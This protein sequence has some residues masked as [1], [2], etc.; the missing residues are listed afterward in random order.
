MNDKPIPALQNSPLRT[1]AGKALREVFTST[2]GKQYI[3][4][5]YCAI[6]MRI[7]DQISR[8]KS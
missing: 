1:E 7:I 8:V 5:D 2:T 4:M 6:E 3:E